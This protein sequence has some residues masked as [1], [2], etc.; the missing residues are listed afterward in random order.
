[1]TPRS[2]NEGNPVNAF[3]VESYLILLTIPVQSSEPNA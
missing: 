2:S 3:V 1:G